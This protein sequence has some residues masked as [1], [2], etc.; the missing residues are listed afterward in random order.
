MLDVAKSFRIYFTSGGFACH[1]IASRLALLLPSIFLAFAFASQVSFAVWS[2]WWFQV[3]V[4]Q[5]IEGIFMRIQQV[6]SSFVVLC[7]SVSIEGH[8]IE[9]SLL[10]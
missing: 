5:T 10:G 4:M 7:F 3:G 2:S 1:C 6:A 9:V 8:F